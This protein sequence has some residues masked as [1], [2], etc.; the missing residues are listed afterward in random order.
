MI[1]SGM[2][3]PV[4]ISLTTKYNAAN[5]PKRPMCNSAAE[6]SV[7]DCIMIV[8][9]LAGSSIGFGVEVVA[10][11]SSLG[12][13]ERKRGVLDRLLGRLRSSAGKPPEQ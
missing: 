3:S 5:I 10:E 9:V 2:D 1:W 13:E 4:D 12:M 6:S 8:V 11:K 7:L